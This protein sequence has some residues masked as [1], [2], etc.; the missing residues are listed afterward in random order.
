MNHFK[1]IGGDKA[2]L[3]ILFAGNTIKQAL[4]PL[5]VKKN[6]IRI[7]FFTSCEE[8][9]NIATDDQPGC[10]PINQE[11]IIRALQNEQQYADLIII[12]LH[13]GPEYYPIP[14]PRIKSLCRNLTNYGVSAIICHH[15]YIISSYEIYNSVPIFY[16]LGNFL[17][18]LGNPKLFPKNYTGLMVKISFNKKKATNYELKPF[19][20]NQ[21]KISLVDL[22]ETENNDFIARMH[23]Y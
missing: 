17:F 14:T 22:N 15:S 4:L 11:E 9:F 2:D 1:V 21:E 12:T 16:G 5:R 8:A 3:N 13:A 23:T 10:A 20:Y 19:T 18:D 7:T 6:S